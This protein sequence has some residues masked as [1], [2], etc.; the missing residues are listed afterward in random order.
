MKKEEVTAGVKKWTHWWIGQRQKKLTELMSETMSINPFMMPFL[1]EYHSLNNF[2]EV[3]EMIISKHLIT[4]H[5]TGFGKLIDEK[6]LPNVFG[7]QKLDKKFR[8]QTPPFNQ[9][10]FDEIDHIITRDN[11]KVDLLSLKAGKWTIQLTMAVQL[12]H[13]FEEILS[14]HSGEF[15][16]IVVGVF[17]GKQADLT[18]KYRILRG[19]NTGANHSVTDLTEHVQ[20]YAGKEFWSWLNDGECDTQIWVLEAIE[21]A[22]KEA[23]IKSSNKKLIDDFKLHVVDKYNKTV[24]T[25]DGDADWSKLLEMING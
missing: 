5:D 23:D 17:Y 20:V 11:G 24:L 8:E 9:P 16:N 19:I 15:D 10:C 14:N 3:V 25:K 6:I 12:N 2:D 4:G 1:F 13:S 21:E 22:V 18:D 7:A